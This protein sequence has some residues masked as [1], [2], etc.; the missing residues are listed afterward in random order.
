M[1]TKFL[2]AAAALALSG[3]AYAGVA[4]APASSEAP[5]GSVIATS[6]ATQALAGSSAGTRTTVVVGAAGKGVLEGL[7]NSG[8][9]T[10]ET[11]NGVTTLKGVTLLVGDQRVLVDITF[12]NDGSITFVRL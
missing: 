9:V 7:K 8:N 4:V 1:N 11:I 2:I 5:V 3:G 12:N 10:T 6:T